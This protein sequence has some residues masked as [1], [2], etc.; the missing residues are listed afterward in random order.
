MMTLRPLIWLA[1][2][3]VDKEILAGSFVALRTQIELRWREI[4]RMVY[5]ADDLA[6]GTSKMTRF[7]GK[8]AGL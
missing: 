8:K 5:L 7:Q 4:L 1:S 6:D 3:H 2:I